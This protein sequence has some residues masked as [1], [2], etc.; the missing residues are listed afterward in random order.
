MCNNIRANI[1][2]KQEVN[3]RVKDKISDWQEERP[4]IKSNIVAKSLRM[5]SGDKITYAKGHTL[6][7]HDKTRIYEIS[8]ENPD[9]IF[10]TICIKFASYK[11][12]NVRVVRI[13]RYVKDNLEDIER[14]LEHSQSIC[15]TRNIDLQ[16][17]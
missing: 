11:T 13:K 16:Y 8:S 12:R 14:F 3:V 7:L 2:T 4:V 5:N 17:K 9:K 15:Q 6:K 1:L 10:K